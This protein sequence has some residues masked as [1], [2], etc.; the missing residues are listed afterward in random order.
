MD[1]KLTFHS[2]VFKFLTTVVCL[3]LVSHDV[4]AGSYEI[5]FSGI[6]T[7]CDQDCQDAGLGELQDTSFSGRLVFPDS[8][9]KAVS[10]NH[11]IGNV[12][13]VSNQSFYTFTLEDAYFTLDSE[14]EAFDLDGLIAPIFWLN[15][16]IE[17]A[18]FCEPQN[19]F[20]LASV[21]TNSHSFFFYMSSIDFPV[22]PSTSTAPPF[23]AV[24]LKI[25]NRQ[26]LATAAS[27]ARFDI[28]PLDNSASIHVD[29]SFFPGPYMDINFVYKPSSKAIPFA[30][31]LALLFL[32]AMAFFSVRKHLLK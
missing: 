16:C 4:F 25:P 6:L 29:S 7:N 5:E 9:D 19:S 27:D 17:S 30:P 31:P 14:I 12:P 22:L 10:Q 32:L 23:S 1:A 13:R 24:S 26:I 28:E 18:A 20:V 8:I 15:D 2:I 21:N 11:L 3:L